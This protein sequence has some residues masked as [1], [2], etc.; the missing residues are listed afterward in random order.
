MA[1]YATRAELDAYIEGGHGLGNDEADRLLERAS[2]DV[3]AVLG[4]LAPIAAGDYEGLKLDPTRLLD[5]E[6]EALSRATCAQAEYR[7][8]V[9]EEAWVSAAGNVKRE[10]GPDFTLEYEEGGRP[11][12][13]V[14]VKV[15]AELEP[16][17][18]LRRMTG[19]AR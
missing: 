11:S 7:Q 18:H 2:R 16:I 14:G 13:R 8:D 3:D 17:R 1:A 4:P 5:W 12:G 9:G 19:Y 6:A 15:A 10:S